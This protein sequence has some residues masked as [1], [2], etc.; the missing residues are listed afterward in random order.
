MDRVKKIADLYL[1]SLLKISE[2]DEETTQQLLENEGI[3]TTA[4][5]TK[6]LKN[7]RNYEFALMEQAATEQQQELLDTIM[8][9]ID[10]LMLR[11]PEQIKAII[12]S[13]I[14]PRMPVFSFKPK[15][16]KSDISAVFNMIDA[17]QLL[18]K[19]KAIERDLN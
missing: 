9:K 18:E 4:L 10:A 16:Y 17:V 1:D 12:N 7:I 6:T 14:Q 8:E 15:S 2:Q 11:V 19:L 3:N 5:V 13:F